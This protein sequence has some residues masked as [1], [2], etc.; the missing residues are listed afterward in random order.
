MLHK[1][2]TAKQYGLPAWDPQ[3]GN[4]G[5]T[6]GHQAL[7]GTHEAQPAQHDDRIVS[8]ATKL[9]MF[10]PGYTEAILLN[11]ITLHCP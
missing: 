5:V 1:Q 8:T 10:T 3:G 7:R 2:S 6:R 4:K 11:Y 9:H